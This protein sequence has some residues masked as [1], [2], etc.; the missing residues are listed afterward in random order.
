MNLG[1]I[2]FNYASINGDGDRF[3]YFYI[4]DKHEDKYYGLVC[5]LHFLDGYKKFAIFGLFIIGHV[6]ILAWFKSSIC[7]AITTHKAI[8]PGYGEVKVCSSNVQ[9]FLVIHLEK[10]C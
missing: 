9:P 2:F 4:L 1:I 7:D 6:C 5:I 8:I 10:D 3:V